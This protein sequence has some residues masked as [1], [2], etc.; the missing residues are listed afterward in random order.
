MRERLLYIDQMRGLAILLVVMAH[1]IQTNMFGWS[2]N[3]TFVAI[4]SF[5]MPLFFFISGYIAHKTNKIDNLRQYSIFLL[6]KMRALLL[7][8][9][10]WTLLI[11]KYFFSIKYE[12]ISWNEVFRTFTTPGLWFL[13]TLFEIFILYGL[14]NCVA[15]VGIKKIFY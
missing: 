12:T 9:F 15:E 5:H 3:A 2:T 4:N 6:N 8:L 1:F 13:L 7:P 10:F 11:D 14:F